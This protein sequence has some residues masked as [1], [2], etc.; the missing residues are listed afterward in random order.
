MAKKRS[1]ERRGDCERRL[2]GATLS[3]VR[4]NGKNYEVRI[5]R[6]SNGDIVSMTER[7]KILD[8]F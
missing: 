1:E 5:V 4:A 7:E 6:D 8:L 2:A 3:D